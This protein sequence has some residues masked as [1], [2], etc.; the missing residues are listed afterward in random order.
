MQVEKN[1]E[2]ILVTG[3]NVMLWHGHYFRCSIGRTGITSEKHEGDGASPSGTF[4]LRAL[5]YRADRIAEPHTQLPVRAINRY[6]GWCNAVGDP[7]YNRLVKMPYAATAEKLW[8]KDASYDV[9]IILGHNDSPIVQGRGSAIFLHCAKD[10]YSATEGCVAAELND[11]LTI[12]RDC[13]SYTSLC[14]RE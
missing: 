6:D 9:L 8:R 7:N 10:D 4:A 3:N 2:V 13:D 14:L 1:P 12:V 5:L 11:L